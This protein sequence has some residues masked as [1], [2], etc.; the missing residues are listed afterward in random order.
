MHPFGN[1]VSD[2][3]SDIHRVRHNNRRDEHPCQLPLHLLE[4]IVLMSTDIGDVILDPFSG[5]GTTAIAAKTLQRNYIGIELDESYAR[6][7]EAKLEQVKPTTFQGVPVSM[8]LGKIHTIRDLDAK[9]M[10]AAQLTSVEKKR[11]R[12]QVKLTADVMH[13]S[14]Q[15]K[16]ALPF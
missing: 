13:S 5:T 8:F 9:E 14:Q 3:W 4:R 2:V 6:I 15:S 7:S 11:R 12:S 10:F 1:L 16:P